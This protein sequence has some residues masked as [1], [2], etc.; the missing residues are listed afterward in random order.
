M[1][2]LLL[3]HVLAAIL[4]VGANLTYAIWFRAAGTNQDRIVFVIR[5]VRLIDNRVA[6]P[7]Y[8]VLLVTGLLMVAGG[9]VSLTAGWILAA[10]A[11][12]VA[13]AVIGLALFSPAIRRQLAEAERDVT[14]ESYQ[15]AAVRSTALGIV[16]TVLVVIIVVLMVTKPF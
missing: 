10:L 14:S 11:L 7:A 12:Y 6:N 15:A 8:I 1:S 16:T 5:T 2:I 13:T 9:V 4:A 3:I